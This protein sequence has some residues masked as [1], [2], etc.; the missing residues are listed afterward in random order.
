[1]RSRRTLLA[2]LGGI[3]AFAIVVGSAASL[4]GIT[5]TSLGA[6]DSVVASCDTD[7]VTSSYSTVYNTTTTAGTKVNDVTIGG[8]DAACHG[9]SM[10]VTLV[11]TSN[12]S[13]GEVTQAVPGTGTTNVL[14]FVTP[15]VLA[16][17]VTGIHVVIT[18]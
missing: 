10:T 1:M 2:I 9:K 4:G 13:I 18:G 3:A 11:N 6:D 15:N 14:N 17:N 12:A 5:S 8:L 16:E 7:G